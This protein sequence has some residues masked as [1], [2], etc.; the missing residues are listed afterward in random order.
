MNIN[1]FDTLPLARLDALD[2]GTYTF[3]LDSNSFFF[4]I[5]KI[6]PNYNSIY[7]CKKEIAPFKV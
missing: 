2:L 4:I 6:K 7:N 3:E 5:K 1:L